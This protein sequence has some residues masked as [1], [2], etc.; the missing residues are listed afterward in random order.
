[1]YNFE[2]FQREFF[3]PLK[4][5]VQ[6][7]HPPSSRSSK[8]LTPLPVDHPPYCW[9]K[10]DQPLR[11]HDWHFFHW[12]YLGG[13]VEMSIPSCCH[14][15]LAAASAAIKVTCLYWRSCIYTVV[16]QTQT[17][18]CSVQLT[19]FS[20]VFLTQE[21]YYWGVFNQTERG[22]HFTHYPSVRHMNINKYFNSGLLICHEE[23]LFSRGPYKHILEH[24]N[25]DMIDLILR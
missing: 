12:T 17:N 20:S 6:F 24:V 2:L 21:K 4:R 10:N 16:E 23:Y 25:D 5:T 14:C 8:I 9:V 22:L 15:L 11:T 13:W 19:Q 7:F 3:N 18:S 1:M